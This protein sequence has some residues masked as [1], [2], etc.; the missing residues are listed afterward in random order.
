MADSVYSSP[1]ISFHCVKRMVFKEIHL[2]GACVP[3]EHRRRRRWLLRHLHRCTRWP[4]KHWRCS[5]DNLCTKEF[6]RFPPDSLQCNHCNNGGCP[7]TPS[8]TDGV[9]WCSKPSVL[10]GI[11]CCWKCTLF[12]SLMNASNLLP[13]DFLASWWSCVSMKSQLWVHMHYWITFFSDHSRSQMNKLVWYGSTPQPWGLL[14]FLVKNP[15]LNL[16][17]P[18]LLGRGRSKVYIII[19]SF[20]SQATLGALFLAARVGNTWLKHV[21]TQT[22]LKE[23]TGDWSWKPPLNSIFL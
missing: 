14:H 4:R 18:L 23:M 16:Y 8:A 13:W 21:H 15:N 17:L 22:L 6:P 11:S 7:K 12:W 3:C 10:A 20:I 1:Y 5:N 2:Q 19:I 9:G